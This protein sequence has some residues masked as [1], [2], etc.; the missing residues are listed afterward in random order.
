MAT[1]AR[2]IYRERRRVAVV[3]GLATIAGY[4]FYS[5][6]TDVVAGVPVAVLA[7]LLYGV[8]F[9]LAALIVSLLAPN[10][11]FTMEAFAV[12]RL[13]YAVSAAGIPALGAATVANPFLNA[14]IVVGGGLLISLA[15]YGE[16][17]SRRFVAPATVVRLRVPQG[18]PA[19]ARLTAPDDV[20]D[21]LCYHADGS[22]P[23]AHLNRV[24]SRAAID[25]VE[26]DPSDPRNLRIPA[27]PM[28]W[29]IRVAAWLDD[30]W[31][32]LYDHAAG[33]NDVPT[34]RPSAEALGPA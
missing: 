34:E 32:R 22:G 27:G 1:L 20:L 30:T 33:P 9:G 18:A 26:R 23:R 21:R 16:P 2:R 29:G 6:V 4:L 13:L 31:G 5:H 24:L 11:R 28:P 17:A 12:A 14:A 8:S 7:A 25:R 10:F 3:S 15:V 19:P